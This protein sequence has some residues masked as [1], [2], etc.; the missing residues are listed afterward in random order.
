MYP[1]RHLQHTMNLRVREMPGQLLH[2]FPASASPAGLLIG[3]SHT[4]RVRL[5]DV[6]A[7]IL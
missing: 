2:A 7:Y 6:A 3:R 1:Y 5:T 4:D